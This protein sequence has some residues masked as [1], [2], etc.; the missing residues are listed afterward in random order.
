MGYS[1]INRSYSG[2]DESGIVMG[3]KNDNSLIIYL[4]S[5]QKTIYEPQRKTKAVAFV[6]DQLIEE[7]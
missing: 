3:E 6:L 7:T 1:S 2:R 4:A 5:R